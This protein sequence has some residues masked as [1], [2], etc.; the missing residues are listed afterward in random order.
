[1]NIV[2]TFQVPSFYIYSIYSE[3]KD[4]LLSNVQW[5]NY[6]INDKGVFRTGQ[7]LFFEENYKFLI[8]MIKLRF[9]L[10]N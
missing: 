1:M 2:S 5:F 9:S 8:S 6:L 10:Q 7:K 3:Q 4:N